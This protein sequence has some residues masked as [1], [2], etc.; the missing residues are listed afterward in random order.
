[1]DNRQQIADAVSYLCKKGEETFD[2]IAPVKDRNAGLG[3]KL[4]FIESFVG[5][6][7]HIAL[8]K[9]DVLNVKSAA[10]QQAEQAKAKEAAEA[11]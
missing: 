10:E 7:V 8:N 5:T 6:C 9:A 2:A 1:M 3:P 11:Q 4:K